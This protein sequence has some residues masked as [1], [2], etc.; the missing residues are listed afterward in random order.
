[1]GAWSVPQAWPLTSILAALHLGGSMVV[2]YEDAH[3]M[4][5]LLGS[6]LARDVQLARSD[7]ADGADHRCGAT[8][9]SA[10]IQCSAETFSGAAGVW[11]AGLESQ[12]GDYLDTG[13]EAIFAKQS[14]IPRK[15]AWPLTSL[16]TALHL[17][18]GSSMVVLCVA[19]SVCNGPAAQFLSLLV[20]W[21]R[22]R[23]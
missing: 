2:M 19:A 10:C 23:C 20:V 6:F 22:R 21:G 7:D 5:L 1:M 11:N 8:G 3:N 16:L 17:G 4:G 15:Q 18:P 14:C 9:A 12:A 13:S